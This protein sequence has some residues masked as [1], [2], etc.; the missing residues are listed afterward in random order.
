MPSGAPICAL[1][2]SARRTS[3]SAFTGWRT[4]DCARFD[5]QMQEPTPTSQGEGHQVTLEEQAQTP[6]WP[7][8]QTAEPG[9]PP[10]PSRAATNRKTEYL[11]RTVEQVTVSPTH[12]HTMSRDGRIIRR[13]FT[14]QNPAARA[15]CKPRKRRVRRLRRP[16]TPRTTQDRASTKAGGTAIL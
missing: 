2:A 4:P 11:G 10:R 1:R 16:R 7:T 15:W 14:G 6:G 13:R 3:D 8:P 12:K 9:G 5:G